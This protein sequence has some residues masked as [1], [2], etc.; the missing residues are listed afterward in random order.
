MVMNSYSGYTLEA[1]QHQT[2]A[3]QNC[4]SSANM[5]YSC[6]PHI[7]HQRNKPCRVPNLDVPTTDGFEAVSSGRCAVHTTRAEAAP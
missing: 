6:L 2:E 1:R 3:V 7:K 5:D 4:L